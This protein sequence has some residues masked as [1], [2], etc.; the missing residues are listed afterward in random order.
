MLANSSIQN[1]LI[2]YLNISLPWI[3][4]PA[5]AIE[6][7]ASEVDGYGDYDSEQIAEMLA[8]LPAQQ[9]SAAPNVDEDEFESLYHWFLS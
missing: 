9:I 5:S 1:S 4:R 2:S 6:V 3:V 8:S 7:K